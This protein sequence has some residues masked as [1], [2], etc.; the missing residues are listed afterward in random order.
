MGK[1]KGP[2]LVTLFHLWLSL[3]FGNQFISP[4]KIHPTIAH[5]AITA[6]TITHIQSFSEADLHIIL[7]MYMFVATEESSSPCRRQGNEV[8]GGTVM[9][10]ISSNE[11]KCSD[12]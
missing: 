5:K 11:E 8:G 7:F 4:G 2:S 12:E 10:K 1:N 6:S 3:I 9:C